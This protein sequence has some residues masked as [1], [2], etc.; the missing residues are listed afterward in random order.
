MLSADDE[1]WFTVC[2]STQELH[3]K[4]RVNTQLERVLSHA[5][6]LRQV[7]KIDCMKCIKFKYNSEVLASAAFAKIAGEFSRVECIDTSYDEQAKYKKQF[8]FNLFMPA[9]EVMQKY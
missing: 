4:Y 1:V 3:E 6:A 5:R 8:D 2:G 9:D 7:K